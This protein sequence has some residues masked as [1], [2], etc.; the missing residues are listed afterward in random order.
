MS[1]EQ[2]NKAIVGRWFTNFWG[3]TYS[4][5]IVDELA[6]P[7]MLLQYSLHEPRRGHADIKAFMSDFRKAF[8]D[9]NFWGA[10]DL[11]AEGDYVVGRWQGGGTHTGP[12][13]SDSSSDHFPLQP[14]A[15]CTSPEP[16]FC[17]LRTARWSKRSASTTASQ[18]SNNSASCA[19]KT[20][21][22]I[23]TCASKP[24]NR[25]LSAPPAAT[26]RATP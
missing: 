21:V 15:R 5:S 19:L 24:N 26:D 22:L 9:L 11:I 18:H 17:A 6:A 12:A 14:V 4:P 20:I 2:D 16:P 23:V 10:A 1:R 7:N 13:F 8:P 25:S 3:K